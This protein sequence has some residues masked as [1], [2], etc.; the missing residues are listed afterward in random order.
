MNALAIALL[1]NAVLAIPLALI[2]W[3]LARR[4][5]RPALLHV[6]WGLVLLRLLAPP[7]LPVPLLPEPAS[8]ASAE[9]QIA[10]P[11]DWAELL[12]AAEAAPG[13]P[14]E[15]PRE[16]LTPVE[17]DQPQSEPSASS[18]W[19][20]VAKFGGV[21]WLLGTLVVLA[22]GL[23]RIRRFRRG[24]RSARP[25]G[26]ELE[27]E[28]AQVAA[29]IG[30]RRAPRLELHDATL[31]PLIWSFFCAPRLLLPQR[32]IDDLDADE[33]RMIL[34]HECAHL[35]RRD[36][37]WRYAEM[38]A[39][40]IFFWN[41]V[42]WWA[43]RELRSAEEH[44]CD[45]WA[46]WAY[47]RLRDAYASAFLRTVEFLSGQRQRAPLAA[48]GV[49]SLLPV[50]RRLNMILG[51]D[52]TRAPG[53]RARW[54]FALV[55]LLAVCVLPV[56]A[57][58]SEEQEREAT[59]RRAAAQVQINVLIDLVRGMEGK[60]EAIELLEKARGMIGGG[61][62]L[63]VPSELVLKLE[64]TPVKELVVADLPLSDL[65]RHFSSA[66]DLNIVV[67]HD[68]MKSTKKASAEWKELSLIDT[69]RA[70]GEVYGFSPKVDGDVL[71][72]QPRKTARSAG[73]LFQIYDVRDL[74]GGKNPPLNTEAL[75]DLIMENVELTPGAEITSEKTGSQLIVRAVSKDHGLIQ[76][77][78]VDLRRFHAPSIIDP[79]PA[80][81]ASIE[82]L[83]RELRELQREVQ[84]MRR[85]QRGDDQGW[86]SPRSR[87][88][89]QVR[90]EDGHPIE[91]ARVEVEDSA[92]GARI[93]GRVID[94]KGQPVKGAKV[95]LA[96][97]KDGKAVQRVKTDEDGRFEIES[98][99]VGRYRLSAEGVG[100][101]RVYD[102]QTGNRSDS[103]LDIILAKPA[104]K[105]SGGD[106]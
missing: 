9:A 29:R 13:E 77:F 62:Q 47:P 34:S 6:L 42:L 4:L 91:G 97:P 12:A 43:R 98:L 87:I 35:L 38:A 28:L 84:R 67:D 68:L 64:T 20:D 65:A 48:L 86:R 55:G 96:E 21:A 16:V 69:L 37:L 40:L 79:K 70:A 102:L 95:E 44:S 100:V 31:P 32:L 60:A 10:E 76:E 41:P 89:G 18:M 52:G 90:D 88:R 56:R 53:L 81:A 105:K 74:A 36:H 45:A 71:R 51:N 58:R 75:S 46:L 7:L 106:R 94:E 93:S 57:Q 39:V 30:L 24:L 49:D 99:P 92:E 11:V 63:R 8:P 61:Q 85:A 1:E 27:G 14:S 26:P 72:L 5:Q 80:S 33:L 104:K 23:S 2:V 22:L 25:A 73:P 82:K 103:R 66:Y 101:K 19:I 50:K 3:L 17:L 15:G 59:E 54:C 83:A 78:L